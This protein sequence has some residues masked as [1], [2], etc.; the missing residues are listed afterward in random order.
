MTRRWAQRSR[1]ARVDR[2]AKLIALTALTSIITLGAWNLPRTATAPT[3]LP[4]R[5]VDTSAAKCAYSEDNQQPVGTIM[6]AGVDLTLSSGATLSVITAATRV[7]T[8]VDPETVR[9]PT[10]VTAKVNVPFAISS[11]GHRVAYLDAR[12]HQFV[13]MDLRTGSSRTLTPVLSAE[14]IGKVASLAIS[15]DGRLFA[16]SLWMYPRTIVTDFDTG[17]A[18]D[19][20]GICRVEGLNDDVVVGTRW[21][22]E[23]RYSAFDAFVA[24]RRDGSTATLDGT[25]LA[26]PTAEGVYLT[27]PDD[28]RNLLLHDLKTGRM[29]PG[30]R[31]PR[32]LAVIGWLDEQHVLARSGDGFY[33]FHV[34]TGASEQLD[35][36]PDD[37]PSQGIWSFG[38]VS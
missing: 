18:R 27:F 5:Y 9:W 2:Y 8:P 37:L 13:A 6:C 26:G 20:P 36:I 22:E 14:E 23:D 7:V 25:F 19:L 38:K 4:A 30:A 24:V 12:V 31:L 34:R 28:P 16:V 32:D 1:E 17:L 3:P 33:R 29:T 11:D 15:M 21:C 35:G 10:Q